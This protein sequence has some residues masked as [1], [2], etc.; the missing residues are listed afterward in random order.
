MFDHIPECFDFAR[1]CGIFPEAGGMITQWALGFYE[2][3][4][5]KPGMIA[6]NFWI[7]PEASSMALKDHV[8]YCRPGLKS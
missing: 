3:F 4:L 7:I 1:D 2:L 6:R 8:K 5:Q